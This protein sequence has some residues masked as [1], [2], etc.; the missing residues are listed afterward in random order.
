MLLSDSAMRPDSSRM[1][2]RIRAS[3]TSLRLELV[4]AIGVT[5]RLMLSPYMS[6]WL[7]ISPVK[8]MICGWVARVCMDSMKASWATFQLHAMRRCTWAMDTECSKL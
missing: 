7:S 1:S 3:S 5:L 6:Y 8:V 4:T 2:R